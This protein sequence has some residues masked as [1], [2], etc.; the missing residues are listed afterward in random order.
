MGII[1]HYRHSKSFKSKLLISACCLLVLCAISAWLYHLI[2]APL[3]ISRPS[4]LLIKPGT[5]ITQLSRQLQARGIIQHPR[6]LVLFADVTGRANRLRYGAYQLTPGMSAEVLL[7]NITHGQG[8]VRY[9]ITFIEGWTFRHMRQALQS[10][11]HIKHVLQDKTQ[12]QVMA[13]LGHPKQHPEGR[14]FPDTYEFTWGVSSLQILSMAYQ[15]MQAV[16]AEQW[17]TRAEAL[18][19]RNAYQGVIVASMIEKETALNSERPIVASVI[20]NRLKKHMRLQIDP[21]VLYGLGKP[22]GSAITK[23]DLQSKTPYNTYVIYGLPPT[24]IDM[25]S[26]ASIKAAFHP[27]KTEYLY[28]MARADGSHVFS[29]TYKAHKKAVQRYRPEWEEQRR[30]DQLRKQQLT[31]TLQQEAFWLATV[32][33]IIEW[34]NL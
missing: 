14:F 29:T 4:I 31:Q 25:P 28:Y 11:P 15:K 12:Q 9:H 19:Y 26:L 24:P 6:A 23:Q 32:V 33:N 10:D 5:T 8:L 13:L 18:P 17:Q 21:T 16:L 7:Y 30:E 27:A 34:V 2:Y 20:L 22:Y 1:S 3:H